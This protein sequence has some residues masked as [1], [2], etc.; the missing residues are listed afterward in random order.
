M[1]ITM[2]A[3]N[4]T[5]KMQSRSCG[6]RSRGVSMME[7]ALATIIVGLSV[8]SIVNLIT[9]VTQ[10]N[11]VAQK[12]TTALMLADNIRELTN[13]LPYNSAT[14]GNHLGP[15]TGMTTVSQYTDV[16][17]FNGF[18]ANPPIDAHGQTI[19]NMSNWQQS[20]TVTHVSPSNFRLTD[21]LPTDSSCVIDR[22]QVTISYLPQGSTTW[23]S[24]ATVEWLKSKL[25]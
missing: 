22:V 23:Q 10:Q 3:P 4:I 8:L 2:D 20:V 16:Q 25:Q 15:L 7:T 24:I 18:T 5:A 19:T 9:A 11:F 13:G 21:S 14:Q 17:C 1:D 12:T 6:R